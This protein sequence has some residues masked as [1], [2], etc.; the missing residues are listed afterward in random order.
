MTFLRPFFVLRAAS[1]AAAPLQIRFNN[2]MLSTVGATALQ[3]VATLAAPN[4]GGK[5]HFPGGSA[6]KLS[7]GDDVGIAM[8]VVV[9]LALAVIV[10]LYVRRSKAAAKFETD[11]TMASGFLAHE[12]VMVMA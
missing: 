12:E 1:I 6:E 9:A 7:A 5:H 11:T 2:S 8:A 4:G 10:G 3:S